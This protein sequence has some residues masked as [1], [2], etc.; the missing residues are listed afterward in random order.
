[1]LELRPSP[2]AAGSG[3][4]Q[5]ASWGSCPPRPCHQ[6]QQWAVSSG[7]R[8]QHSQGCFLR[9]MLSA[10]LGSPDHR[11]FFH[12]NGSTEPASAIS[13]GRRNVQI[14]ASSIFTAAFSSILTDVRVPEGKGR[15]GKGRRLVAASLLGNLVEM[16]VKC[17]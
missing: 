15:R 1:M 4:S 7:R 8:S 5:Q 12:L 9:L 16:L 14:T 17:P 11:R 13:S 6:G 2:C 10:Y 3:G